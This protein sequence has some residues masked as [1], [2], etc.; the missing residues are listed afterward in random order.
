MRSELSREIE[1]LNDKSK[2]ANLKSKMSQVAHYCQKC[3]ASNPLGQDFCGRCGTPLMIVVD[4][5]SSRYEVVEPYES[6]EEHL[7]E[8]VSALENRV[9]RLTERLERGLDLIS[10]QAKNADSEPGRTE[11]S[12]EDVS[13]VRRSR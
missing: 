1:D 5:P 10:A 3:L 2:I 13:N 9:A 7:M 11:P 12:I 8:R 6:N 4:T